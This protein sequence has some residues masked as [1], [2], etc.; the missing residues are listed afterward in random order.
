MHESAKKFGIPDAKLS[1]LHYAYELY[2]LVNCLGDRRVWSGWDVPLGSKEHASL[3]LP[4][5]EQSQP[6]APGA[7]KKG[8][9]KTDESSSTSDSSSNLGSNLGSSMSMRASVPARVRGASMQSLGSVAEDNGRY[10][11]PVALRAQAFAERSGVTDVL[12]EDGPTMVRES[13]AYLLV[14]VGMGHDRSWVYAS[15]RM[16]WL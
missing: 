8:A 5:D 14:W 11:T 4:F 10:E 13:S 9:A 7:T 1:M 16:D 3:K 2:E 6:L 15:A 12:D